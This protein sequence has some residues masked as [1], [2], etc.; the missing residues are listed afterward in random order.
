MLRRT[1]LLLEQLESRST[2]AAITYIEDF[3]SDYDTF[4][5][6]FD[7]ADTDPATIGIDSYLIRNSLTNGYEG[8][9]NGPSDSNGYYAIMTDP[10]GGFLLKFFD[11]A[12]SGAS[13]MFVMQSASIPGQPADQVCAGFSL[14]VGGTGWI[15]VQ[16]QDATLTANFSSI[17][18]ERMTFSSGSLSADGVSLGPLI[19]VRLGTQSQIDLDNVAVTFEEA[20]RGAG[21]GNVFVRTLGPDLGIMG[22]EKSNAIRVQMLDETTGTVRVI[23]LGGTRVN[24]QSAVAV[25]GISRDAFINMWRGDDFV[26]VTGDPSN[27]NIEF[28]LDDD[29]MFD[30]ESGDDT[31]LLDNVVVGDLLALKARGGHDRLTMLRTTINRLDVHTG[32][33]QDTVTTD[34]FSGTLTP[35]GGVAGPSFISTGG[36]AD[37]V[38]LSLGIR[39][40]LTVRLGDGKDSLAFRS[41]CFA[42]VTLDLGDCNDTLELD[43]ATFEQK[44]T[45]LMGGGKDVL[46]LYYPKFVVSAPGT[47]SAA[48]SAVFRG[49]DGRATLD[50]VGGLEYQ[51]PNGGG[52]AWVTDRSQFLARLDFL[53]AP[54]SF[55]A[56]DFADV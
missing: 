39:S 43:G 40:D 12:G 56:F 42:D 51:N 38:D 3:T 25:N 21:E 36:D 8:P 50:L 24:G 47:G 19:A 7:Q 30:L 4:G 34:A 15:T 2:P 44:L 41:H 6:G 5:P 28:K 31:V 18:R 52:S 22:D 54:I 13:F 37:E 11:Q 14:D 49:E 9:T 48:A 27:Q 23:G 29:L 16:G 20:F 10:Q 53:G 1:R 46:R 26:Q 33:G 17:D 35:L 55:K 45:A 32:G